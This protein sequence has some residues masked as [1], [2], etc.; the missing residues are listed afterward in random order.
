MN[1]HHGSFLTHSEEKLEWSLLFK[2]CEEPKAKLPR[3]SM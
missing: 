3:C 2:P 1:R